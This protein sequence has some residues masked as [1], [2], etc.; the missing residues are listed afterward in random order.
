MTSAGQRTVGMPIDVAVDP[1]PRLCQ[2]YIKMG[3]VIKHHHGQKLLDEKDQFVAATQLYSEISNFILKL[4][5]ESAN[6]PLGLASPLALAYSTLRML[7]KRYSCPSTKNCAPPSTQAAS[8]MQTQAI[9]GLRSVSASIKEFASQ[10][11]DVTPQPQDLDSV[12]P[13]IMDALYS[14][15]AHYAWMVRESGDEAYQNA[16]D[17]LRNTMRKLG[18]RWRSAAEYLRILEAQVSTFAFI[19]SRHLKSGSRFC[20]Q[21]LNCRKS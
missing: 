6:D 17:S 15:A 5:E 16:L 9:E 11:A 8:E 18:V 20:F 1:F 12:S 3:A 7:C 13:I 21:A 10:I 4:T 2:A 19:L 14:A